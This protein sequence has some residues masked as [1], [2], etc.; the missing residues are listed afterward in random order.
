[1]GE[2]L[3]KQVKQVKMSVIYIYIYTDFWELTLV[4]QVP[5]LID[6]TMHT[7]C[8]LGVGTSWLL[9]LI[10]WLLILLSSS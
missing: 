2:Q 5:Y 4:F 3:L 9:L 7:S 6:S 8:G 10:T 1:M